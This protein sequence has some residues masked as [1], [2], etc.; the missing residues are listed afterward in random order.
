VV[1]RPITQKLGTREDIARAIEVAIGAFL[2]R[3]PT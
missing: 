1:L 2:T 3:G